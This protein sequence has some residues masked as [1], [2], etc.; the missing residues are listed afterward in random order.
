MKK[1]QRANFVHSVHEMRKYSECCTLLVLAKRE[2]KRK[3]KLKCSLVMKQLTHL[4][5]VFKNCIGQ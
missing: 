2:A 1:N 5:L 4:S 3:K